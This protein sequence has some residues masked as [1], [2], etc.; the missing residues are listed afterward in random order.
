M[1]VGVPKCWNGSPALV[2]VGRPPTRGTDDIKRVAGSRSPKQNKTVEFR[3]PYKKPMSSNGGL[4]VMKIKPLQLIVVKCS[5]HLLRM[6]WF[7]SE[8]CVEGTLPR[9]CLVWSIRIEVI[10][11]YTIQI[12][13][14]FAEYSKLS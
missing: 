7:R 9:I 14:L 10:I 12:L 6:L 2:S 4:S 3:T 11:N 8:T 1:D 13:L 5:Q